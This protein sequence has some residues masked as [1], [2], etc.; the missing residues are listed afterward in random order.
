[1]KTIATVVT[2]GVI[3]GLTNGL[4]ATPGL[5]HAEKSGTV[6]PDGAR[7]TSAPE[8][9][10]LRFSDPARLMKVDI[11][12]E[13]GG[14]SDDI[15]VAIPTRAKIETITLTPDLDGA[16]LYRVRWRALGA[17]GH[18]MTGGFSFSVAGE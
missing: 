1:M 18:V 9:L 4:A 14:R 13:R 6:P 7:L 12:R 5:A 10:E 16:G 8:R 15:G 17:D 2:A 3:A 11:V